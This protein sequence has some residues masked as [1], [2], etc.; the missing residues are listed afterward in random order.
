MIYSQNLSKTKIGKRILILCSISAVISLLVGGVIGYVIVGRISPVEGLKSKVTINGQPIMIAPLYGVYNAPPLTLDQ[1]FT[2]Q[3]VSFQPLEIELDDELQEFIFYL[4]VGYGIDCSLIMAVIQ[5]ESNF[6]A[7]AISNTDDYGLMQINQVNH[8]YLTDI[9]GVTDYLD[10]YQNIEAGMFTIGQLFKKYGDTNKVLM[11]YN[12][13][14][15]GAAVL[16]E[17][18]IYTTQ[19]TKNVLEIQHG[20]KER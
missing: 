19:Y 15:S 5:Q 6:R 1:S 7:D 11:A 4:S 13:G 17:R 8:A 18:G 2:W 9:L 20:Y 3:G 14:E 16:W 12:M 10:P